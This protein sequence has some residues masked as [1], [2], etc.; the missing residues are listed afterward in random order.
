MPKF[1]KIITVLV[2]ILMS[3]GCWGD[4]N[5]CELWAGK[6]ARG[7]EIAPS[8]RELQLGKCVES[9]TL[10]L[11]HLGDPGFED[12][13]LVA[14]IALGRS[15]EA[16]TAVKRALAIPAT[17]EAAAAQVVSWSLSEAEPEL[18]TALADEALA[19][20]RPALLEAALAVSPPEKWSAELVRA[21]GDT[22]NTTAPLVDRALAALAALDL[23]N[24]TPTA[25]EAAIDALAELVTQPA[26]VVPKARAGAAL[27]AMAKVT[28]DGAPPLVRL[29]ERARSGSRMALLV[30]AALGHPEVDGLTLAL[31]TRPE[32]DSSTRWLALALRKGRMTSGTT[33]PGGAEA[34]APAAP[35]APAV[36]A[37]LLSAVTSAPADADTLLGLAMT[38]GPVAAPPLE[39]RRL[40]EKGAARVAIARAQSV[41]LTADELTEWQA[42]LEKEP[43][44]LLRGLPTEPVVLGFAELTRRCG[45]DEALLATFLTEMAP[46]LA[47]LDAELVQA[48]RDVETTRAQAET[49]TLVDSQRAKELAQVTGEAV[50]KARVELAAI[51]ARLEA[52]YKPVEELSHKVDALVR[53]EGEALLALSRLVGT[54]SGATVGKAVL[55]ACAGPACERLRAW[56]VAAMFASEPAV[57]QARFELLLKAASE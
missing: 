7:E 35:A 36:D 3:G 55:E 19:H 57:G 51:Q 43:S 6:L 24:T 53:L 16:E 56:A 8:I 52:A 10:L 45:L 15:P 40:T 28:G 13:I 11:A 48:R 5:P 1:T 22:T 37:P 33:A 32:V 34:A 31:A 47:T 49:Q 21:L 42:A 14:L 20:S 9:R 18:R 4:R 25:R 41:V 38:V 30:L 26:G 27:A 39:Q 23:R 29:V 17:S 2:L 50:A 54:R 46:R 44:V 12:D